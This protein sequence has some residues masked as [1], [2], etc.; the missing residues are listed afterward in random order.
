[1]SIILGPGTGLEDMARYLGS[2][3]DGPGGTRLIT[4]IIHRMMSVERQ[5][6]YARTSLGYM[7]LEADPAALSTWENDVVVVDRP[8]LIL[9]ALITATAFTN[10]DR[11]TLYL[12]SQTGGPAQPGQPVAILKAF[13]ASGN[14]WA[15]SG[16][17]TED[18]LLQGSAT[19][20]T[21]AYEVSLPLYVPP[22]IG[23]SPTDGAD[24]VSRI[25]LE[26]RSTAG[27]ACDTTGVVLFAEVPDLPD[28]A[29]F[30]P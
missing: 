17:R 11:S 8:L 14:G 28:M 6:A 1:M 24:Y 16:T 27:G 19:R 30:T 7:V 4:E 10:V 29:P 23:I 15:F 18:T 22:G 12:E 20:N 26:T 5:I 2:Q 13:D 25:V 3:E 21:E 9:S